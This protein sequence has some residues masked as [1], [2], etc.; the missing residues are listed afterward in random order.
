MILEH[1]ILTVRPGQEQ[2]F[3]AAMKMAKP[4]ISKSAGFR[5]IDV[6]PNLNQPGQYIL[7]VM[8]DSVEDHEEGFRKSARYG[9]WK[10]L[11]HHFYDPFPTVDHFGENIIPGTTAIYEQIGVGYDTARAADPRIA[12]QLIDLLALTGGE[13]ILDIACGTAN[14]TGELAS[15]GLDMTGLDISETMLAAARQK[16]PQ[17]PFILSSAEDIPA[18]DQSFDRVMCTLAIHH[19]PDMAKAFGE[20]ARV[21]R[22]DRLVLFT[23]TSEQTA[24]YWLR[25]YF[26]NA[27]QRAMETDPT[28]DAI[29]SALAR[30][31]F[32]SHAFINWDVPDNLQDKFAYAGKNNPEL[33][34]KPGVMNGISLFSNLGHREEIDA[35]LQA[36]RADIN[37]GK[38]QDIRAQY[39]HDRGDYCFVVAHK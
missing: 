2:E 9:R 34:F 33:Y 38:W 20:A 24:G 19:F 30:A 27:L 3:E 11:L 13:R 16:H 35:G 32:K 6:R 17:L 28:A 22:G 26:P 23:A 18:P 4:L 7:L 5:G 21:L 31:D 14:Y 37:S 29:S 36:L 1:A 39:D 10:E 15:R 12:D 8:W 25:H